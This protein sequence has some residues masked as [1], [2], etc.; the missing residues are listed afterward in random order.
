MGPGGT[1]TVPSTSDQAV[2]NQ[3]Q[4]DAVERGSHKLY[5]IGTIHYK[6]IFEF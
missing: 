6:D 3:G 2:S 1:L 5:V 4:I